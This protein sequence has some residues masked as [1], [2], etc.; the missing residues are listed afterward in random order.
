MVRKIAKVIACVKHYCLN[1]ATW[2][3]QLSLQ[4]IHNKADKP[5]EL[6]WLNFNFPTNI[7]NNQK[8]LIIPAG[9]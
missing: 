8:H 2:N 1:L 4:Q 9:M 3:K 7:E 5:Q 6:F